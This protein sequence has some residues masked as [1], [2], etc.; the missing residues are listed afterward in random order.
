MLICEICGNT[1]NNQRYL[2]WEIRASHYPI[3]STHNLDWSAL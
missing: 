1:N 2:A 3:F